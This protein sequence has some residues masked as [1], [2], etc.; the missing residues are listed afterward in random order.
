MNQ[1][2]RMLAGLPY[3]AW[4]DGLSQERL[5]C[6]EKLRRFNALPCLLYTSPSPRD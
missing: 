1:K 6:Q 3:K 5:A 2:E 4:L